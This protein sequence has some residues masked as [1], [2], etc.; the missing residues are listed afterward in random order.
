M[1]RF[2]RE[3]RVRW[4]VREVRM[5]G[6]MSKERRPKKTKVKTRMEVA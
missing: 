5:G 1:M 2:L 6:W 3:T 4:E